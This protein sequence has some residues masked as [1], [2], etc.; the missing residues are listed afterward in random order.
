[1]GTL[2]YRWPISENMEE[3]SEM[4]K[5]KLAMLLIARLEQ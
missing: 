1:M 2:R 3:G 5:Q 4:H